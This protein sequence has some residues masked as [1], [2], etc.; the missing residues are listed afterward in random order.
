M[1]LTS[2]QVVLADSTQDACLNKAELQ[3]LFDQSHQ[4]PQLLYIWSPRMVLSAQHAVLAARAAQELEMDFVPLTVPGLNDGEKRAALKAL[5]ESANE[6]INKLRPPWAVEYQQSAQLL[7]PSRS[8]CKDVLH[9]LDD[10]ADLDVQLHFPSAFLVQQG[11]IHPNAMRGAMPLD[12]WIS[13]LQLRLASITSAQTQSQALS[14]LEAPS[15]LRLPEAS[16]GAD[17]L[18][19]H[20]QSKPLQQANSK[21]SMDSSARVNRISKITIEPSGSECIPQNEFIPLPESLAGTS[22]DGYGREQVAIGSYERI[23]PDGRF[24]LRSYSGAKIGQ[25]SLVELS[26]PPTTVKKIVASPL[27]NEAFPVQGSWRYLVDVN[28][29]HY[30]FKDIFQ[31][32]KSALPRF[33]GGMAGF[34]A[35]AAE[36][37]EPTVNGGGEAGKTVRIRSLSWPNSTS[38]DPDTQG[39]GN[40]MVRTI[41]VDTQAHR[42][43]NDSQAYQ[44]CAKR[45][46][47]DGR[48][49]SLPMISVNGEE[50]AALPEKAI[51]GQARMKVFSFGED[52]TACQFEEEFGFSSGKTIFGFAQKGQ[53][54][55]DLA[56][57]YKRQV[58][59]YHRASKTAFNIAPYTDSTSLQQ[60][61]LASAFPGIS[62]D[63]RI[64]YA[65]SWKTCSKP[66]KNTNEIKSRS[67]ACQA[68][69]GYI[70]SD[71]WQSNAF[72]TFLAN[73]PTQ[74]GK[75]RYPRC[76]RSQDVVRER[77]NQALAWDIAD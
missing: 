11:R 23:S 75:T 63:G 6:R 59:W 3:V 18:T 24:V 2:F 5:Q 14:L 15:E 67:S 38:D 57:E 31:F 66:V 4:R 21:D 39:A 36:L 8:L 53:S 33:K 35:A 45:R 65:A 62:Q 76:I 56:Y 50:F 28:G 77:K 17:E 25:V 72:R 49:Y 30:L 64:I 61:V 19:L 20:G 48:M 26:A 68:T 22:I 13:A 29:E 69:V 58:W 73:K 27:S 12:F 37:A 16:S 46:A 52:G 51:Q 40:L 55:A 41:E 43:V 44:V 74:D 71:P 47:L 32:G 9:D 10:V 1:T 7:W 34:Y 54:Q 42:V 70:I 60:E